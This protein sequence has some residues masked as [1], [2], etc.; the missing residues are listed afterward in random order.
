MGRQGGEECVLTVCS[1][2]T[3]LSV[4]DGS[5]LLSLCL[6]KKKSEVN[7]SFTKQNT[8]SKTRRATSS[9]ICQVLSV[10]TM[11]T[12]SASV[13]RLALTTNNNI[14]IGYNAALDIFSSYKLD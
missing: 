6:F 14:E 3:H 9:H 8:L 13:M 5:K 7:A 10:T 11:M 12:D 1:A 2:F 4:T